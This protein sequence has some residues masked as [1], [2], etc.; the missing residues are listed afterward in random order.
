M[1]TIWFANVVAMLGIY[2]ILDGFDFGVGIL[3]RF[4]ARTDEERRTV[5]ASIG[6][7]W[8]GNEV[9]LIAAGGVLFMA[10]P[11]VYATAFSG[12]YLALMIVL[13]LLILRGVAMEFRSHNE[14]PLWREFWDSVF[15]LASG[16]LAFVFGAALG[17]LV[18]G[19]PIGET[20]LSGMPLF[21]DFRTGKHPGLFDWYTLLV[22]SFALGAL[23]VH[24]ALYLDWRTTGAVQERSR[25]AVGAIWRILF[26]IWIVVTLATAFV[27]PEIFSNLIARPWSLAFGLLA[28]FGFAGIRYFSIRERPLSAFLSSCTFLLGLLATTMI[29]NYPHWLRSTVDPA[30]SLTAENAASARYGLNVA[31]IWWSAGMLLVLAYFCY[32]FGS[33]RGKVRVDGGGSY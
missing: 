9:W 8:D 31:I 28:L 7:V 18:R 11:K 4:V 30:L 23:A 27:Q 32:L 21:T 16:L 13:W 22:G 3:H 17:N 1:E 14:N 25:S 33:L 24:G 19:V 10:F 15:S 29:G 12:F 26:P 6:P 2:V 20:G 5:L